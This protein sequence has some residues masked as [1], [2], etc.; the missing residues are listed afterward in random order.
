MKNYTVFESHLTNYGK[1]ADSTTWT[2]LKPFTRH[3]TN[4]KSLSAW[5]VSGFFSHIVRITFFY[6]FN[7]FLITKDLFAVVKMWFVIRWSHFSQGL[8]MRQL[9]TNT[10]II[11]STLALSFPS[12]KLP[13]DAGVTVL[14]VGYK[15]RKHENKAVSPK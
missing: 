11:S 14:D 12:F 5:P 2:V 10:S 6:S 9:R 4:L 15:Y 3:T 1:K 8:N 13:L 7:S